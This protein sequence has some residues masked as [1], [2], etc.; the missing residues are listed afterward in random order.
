[1]SHIR[2]A[3]IILAAGYGG[4]IEGWLDAVNDLGIAKRVVLAGALGS[5]LRLA[6]YS[7]KNK[8]L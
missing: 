4:L 3:I 1:M 5:P 2:F 8:Q 7:W 6:V